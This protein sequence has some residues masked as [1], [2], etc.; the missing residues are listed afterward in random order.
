[1]TLDE[2]RQQYPQYNNVPDRDLANALHA[3]FYSDVPQQ[4]FYE[5]LGLT[6]PGPA[7]RAQP[8]KPVMGY[9]NKFGPRAGPM[10]PM[11]SPA[12]ATVRFGTG[13][14][15]MLQGATQMLLNSLPESVVNA[16]NKVGEA[17][18]LDPL[19]APQMNQRM[20][21]R[22]QSIQGDRANAG[23][24]GID[25]ARMG[26]NMAGALPVAAALPAGAG[27]LGTAAMG[28][29]GGAAT[30]A[31]QPVTD[32]SKP[33]WD[34][35]TQQLEVGAGVGAALGPLATLAGRAINPAVNP[36]V[37]MLMDRGVTPTPGQIMGGGA[38]RTEEK[39]S[40]IPLLGDM[41]KNAQRRGIQQFNVAAANEALE[42]IGQALP[43]GTEA[44]RDLIDTV[45]TRIGNAYDAVLNRPATRFVADPQFI[46]EVNQLRGLTANMPEAQARQFENI[47]NN[48]VMT[49]IGGRGAVG[50]GSNIDG[51]T[52]KG[53]ESQLGTLARGYR[54]DPLFDNR[55]LG[56]AV[57]QLQTLLRQGLERSNPTAAPELQ[58][59]NA[60]WARYLRLQKAGQTTTDGAVFTPAQLQAA[61]KGLDPSRNKGQFARGNAMGQDL[62]DAGRNV[63]GS[64]YPDSGTA[65][66]AMLSYLL[67]LGLGAGAGSATGAP[68]VGAGIGAAAAVPYTELGGRLA[69]QILTRRPQLAPQIEAGLLRL[70]PAART[71]GILGLGQ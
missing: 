14:N 4:Q 46:Q 57:Q 70:T 20:A 48:Q 26:G 29:G 63:L 50:P 6:Q 67:S 2:I 69:A 16:G 44:G 42:P 11:P 27:V 23:Q 49:K 24:T 34:Q 65:G 13:A 59:A 7:H 1:M 5:A 64:K 56:D 15:D 39:L 66:R 12:S 3:K 53:I 38:A 58:A 35:K 30:A 51:Q 47:I 19:T 25:W 37:R 41:I 45:A 22:E 55:Q 71:A 18:G 40:S 54:S 8:S 43:R 61:V 10:V 32:A 17:I 52:F 9:N 68:V 36:E 28:A 21:Q 31:M 33:Y 62:A 60:A